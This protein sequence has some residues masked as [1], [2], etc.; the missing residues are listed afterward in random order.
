MTHPFLAL[1]R[2]LASKWLFFCVEAGPSA[3]GISDGRYKQSRPRWAIEKVKAKT[4]RKEKLTGKKN[5][6]ERRF[7]R[8][9]DKVRRRKKKSK[10]EDEGLLGGKRR[11]KL[12]RRENNTFFGCKLSSASAKCEDYWKKK[13]CSLKA[14]NTER[15]SAHNTA[16]I[17]EK[18]VLNFSLS[19]S[20]TVLHSFAISFTCTEKKEKKTGERNGSVEIQ[21]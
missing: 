7:G 11:G 3:L 6:C 13:N 14:A 5:I 4:C 20:E 21:R 8:G 16:K 17:P 15:Q 12:T 18:N 2:S 10:G 9:W 1:W 19:L